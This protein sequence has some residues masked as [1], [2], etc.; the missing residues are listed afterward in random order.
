MLR[1]SKYVK[2]VTYLARFCRGLGRWSLNLM[3]AAEP[4]HVRYLGSA[5]RHGT[6][7]LNSD[8]LVL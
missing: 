2:Y 5:L 1:K 7:T 6:M 3:E 8:M 4:K